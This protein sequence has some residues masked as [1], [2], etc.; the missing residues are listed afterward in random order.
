MTTAV[1]PKREAQQSSG[2]Q[3]PAEVR[4]SEALKRLKSI[5]P[6][7]AAARKLMAMVGSQATDLRGVSDVL[8][9]D[10]VLAGESLRMANSALFALRHEVTSILHAVSVLG[11]D[12]L[13]SVVLTVGLRDMMKTP[14][15]A[16]QRCWRHNLACAWR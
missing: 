6:F 1:E 12:R 8:K 2:P 4:Q 9:S 5:P 16:A 11:L 13:K 7:P 15:A 3:S 14:S 10:A